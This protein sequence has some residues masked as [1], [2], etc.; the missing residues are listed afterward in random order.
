MTPISFLATTEPA[1]AKNF[2]GAILGLTLVET[3]PYALVF[4]DGRH[5]L[6]I[7]I[8][9]KLE[10]ASFTVH[11]WQVD[12]IETKVKQLASKGVV[13]EVFDQLPQDDLGVWTTPDGSKIAWFKDPCG[14]TLSLTQF[15]P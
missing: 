15:A 10:P 9:P 8:V 4:R 14:N 3:T 7:Q 11:G 12:H 5:M 6:R 2:Y 1:Q 13:F